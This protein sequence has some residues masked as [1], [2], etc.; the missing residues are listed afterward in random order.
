MKLEP[1]RTE[2]FLRD[3]GAA[4]VVLL[5]GDDAGLITDR[6]LRLV[7]RVAGDAADPFRV[8]ELAR[9][10]RGQLAEEMTTAPLSG[11]RRVVRVREATDAWAAEVEAALAGT[12]AALLI[13]EAP[14]LPSRSRLRAAVERA[15]DAA[16]IGCYAPERDGLGREIR[17]R[18]Q[19]QGV[20]I[21]YGGAGVV[22]DPPGR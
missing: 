20:A 6:A 1:R 13:V 12:G 17:E 11:G 10:V 22:G 8:V 15:P 4:R 16:A 7:R 9:D 3:P 5:Y 21:G 18:L 19:A 14:G 2:A